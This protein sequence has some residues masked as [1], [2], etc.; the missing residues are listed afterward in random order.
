MADPFSKVRPGDELRIPAEAYNAFLDAV[1]WVKTQQRNL[2][3]GTGNEVTDADMVLV[4]NA[5]GDDR[6]RFDILGID[7][8]IF[9]PSDS[10]ETF[11]NQVA[12]RGITPQDAHVGKFV[13]LAEP[14][15]DDQIGR[16]WVSGVCPIKI[17]VRQETDVWADVVSGDATAVS[18]REVECGSLSL[19]R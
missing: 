11:K 4:K 14:I 15:A 19:A 13:V 3:A 5:S 7:E 17:D 1:S 18:Y 8:P 6:N 12:L 2:R 16:A 9:T 10:V